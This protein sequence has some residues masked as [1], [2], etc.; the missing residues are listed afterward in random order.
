MLF[1]SFTPVW[2]LYSIVKH[3]K[4]VTVFPNFMSLGFLTVNKTN[5]KNLNT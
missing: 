3:N 2:Q 5:L 4:K 1:I